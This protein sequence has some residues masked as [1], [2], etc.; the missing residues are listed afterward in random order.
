[1]IHTWFEC[2]IKYEKLAENGMNKT[3]TEPYLVDAI[4][5]TEA[6]ARII[7]EMIPFISGEFTIAGIKRV[8]YSEIFFSENSDK[9]FSARLAF[10]T[11][12]ERSGSERKSLSTI[13]VQASDMDDALKKLHDGMKGTLADY[14]S[15][16]LKETA[17]MDVFVYETDNNEG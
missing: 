6:E 12:D 17:I 8:N 4:S 1:M 11:L 9:Y 16:Q 10:I 13:L 7:E 5:F 15:V 3:A 2:K 14:Q